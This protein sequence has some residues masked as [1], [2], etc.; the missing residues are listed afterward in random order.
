MPHGTQGGVKMQPMGRK[1][2]RFPSKTKEW[3]GKR[4]KMWW[5]E[6]APANKKAARQKAIAEIQEEQANR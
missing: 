1:K 5:E 3:L 6:M 4:I 2:V